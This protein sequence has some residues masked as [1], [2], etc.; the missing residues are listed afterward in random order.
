MHNANPLQRTVEELEAG[1][2]K[3]RQSSQG[4]DKVFPLGAAGMSILADAVDALARSYEFE[5]ARRLLLAGL[6]AIEK[7]QVL[8]VPR[9]LGAY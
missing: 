1:A 2:A 8:T 5:A 3:L 6:A 9:Q 4:S 7:R